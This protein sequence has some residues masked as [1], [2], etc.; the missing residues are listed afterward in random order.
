MGGREAAQIKG[1]S[2]PSE[3]VFKEWSDP[4]DREYDSL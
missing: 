2:R 3:A 4:R 1:L